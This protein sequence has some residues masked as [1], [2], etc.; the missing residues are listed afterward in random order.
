MGS[1]AAAELLGFSHQVMLP[2]LAKE[3]LQ[4]GAGGLG[5]LTACRFLGG[6]L[7]VSVLTGLT[8]WP[9]RGGLLL[10]VL[11][12]FGAGQVLLASAPTFWVAAV[13]VIFINIMATAADVL[14]QTMLQSSV[15]NEQ[16]GRAMGSWIIGTG[17]A[18]VG[19]L[20]IGALASLTSVH[21]ALLVNGLALMLL[22]LGLAVSLPRLWRL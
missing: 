12:L 20:E 17:I 16:R 11:A 3:V 6:V 4:V 13:Y 15:A 21:V 18:P 5:V 7:G 1:T 9:R 10:A 19:H 14:H 2:I 22:T 8:V